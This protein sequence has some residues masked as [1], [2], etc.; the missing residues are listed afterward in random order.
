MFIVFGEKQ[1]I[2]KLGFVAEHCPVCDATR[3]VRINRVGMSPH[4]FWLPLG[5]GRLIGY[6]GVCQR[7]GDQFDIEPTDYV[8]LSRKAVDNLSDLQL[9]T[10]PKLDARNRDAV[11]TFERFACIRDPLLRA[12][13]DLMQRY[14]GGTRFDRTS[15][16]A[17]LATLAIPVV[18]FT[19][20]LTFLSF[21]TQQTI[22]TVSIWAF[23]F[24][25][26]GSFVLVAREPRRFFRRESEPALVKELLKVNPRPDEL[27]DCLKLVRKYE[28]R[29]SAHVST[30]RL[31]NQIQL[32]QFSFHS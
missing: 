8:S 29:V 2:R 15:G 14:A 24:G 19:T 22:G 6:Y 28:Y 3:Q 18:M 16:L 26:I 4:I 23:I 7:C 12:N 31:L 9:V 1:A 17:F 13:K 5:K 27:E 30:R 25:L 32:Q 20:D 10:N 21:S 11:A